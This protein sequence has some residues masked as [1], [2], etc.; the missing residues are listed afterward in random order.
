M[1]PSALQYLQ[2]GSFHPLIYQFH[3][4][5]I[6]HH[7]P[8]LLRAQERSH[9]GTFT[10][11]S[12]FLCNEKY[13]HIV[14]LLGGLHLAIR[15]ITILLDLGLGEGVNFEGNAFEETTCWIHIA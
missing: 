3:P 1:L 7:R 14:L 4:P 15:L 9:C 5:I 2:R 10:M 8:N 12:K 11:A 6:D 13:D